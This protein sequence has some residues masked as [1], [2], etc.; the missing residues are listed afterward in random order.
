MQLEAAQA[1]AAKARKLC[2]EAPND[3]AFQERLAQAEEVLQVVEE[4]SQ[5][6]VARGKAAHVRVSPTEPEA[7]YQPSKTPAT[8]TT[9]AFAYSYKP[10]V[11]ANRD[12]L[13]VA[14]SVHASSEVAQ[15]EG[16][17]DQAEKVAPGELQRLML[18][19]GY[20][21]GAVAE[22]ALN[23]DLDLLCPQGKN[24]KTSGS[25]KGKKKQYFPKER[26]EYDAEEDV[27]RCPANKILRPLWKSG[28]TKQTDV[29][30]GGAPCKLCP[31]KK[32]CTAKSKRIVTR[33]LTKAQE[34]ALGA[35][36]EVMEFPSAI[37][38]YGD[39][40]SMVEP[41]FAHM[42]QVGLSRFTRRGTLGAA[43]EFALRSVAH[44]LKRFAALVIG[45]LGSWLTWALRL[46]D[47][48]RA[49]LV[50]NLGPHGMARGPRLI[51]V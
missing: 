37:E 44:N 48:T 29:Q 20:Y 12:R 3:R 49:D 31:L 26:F 6:R 27:Y 7:V 23:R 42:R 34:A 21:S 38:A 46:A 24:P 1:G 5:R 50:V 47:R 15:V 14:Q 17:L 19:A 18:D 41:V 13:I 9:K 16:L 30:Y 25:K 11:L 43:L 2:D 36:R 35:S 28:A 40:A 45:L 8:A 32:Q 4:R 22:L 33:R 39:R 10:S 51:A